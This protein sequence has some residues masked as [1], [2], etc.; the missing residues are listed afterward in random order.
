MV[1]YRELMVIAAL[2]GVD[3]AAGEWDSGSNTMDSGTTINTMNTNSEAYTDVT[4]HVHS[5]TP[6]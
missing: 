2:A 3:A 5:H 1:S 6:I 4:L